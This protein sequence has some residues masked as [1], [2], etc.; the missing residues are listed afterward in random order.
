[1][2]C[3]K[4]AHGS[5]ECSLCGERFCDAQCWERSK[6][7]PICAS[8]PIGMAEELKEERLQRGQ[9]D[10]DFLLAVT[11]IKSSACFVGD[12]V[13]Y[14]LLGEEHTIKKHIIPN[15][16]DLE[17]LDGKLL[18]KGNDTRVMSAPRFLYALAAASKRNKQHMDLFLELDYIPQSLMHPER[19]WRLPRLSAYDMDIIAAVFSHMGCGSLVREEK[20]RCDV[21]PY[22]RFH[23]AD[24]RTKP[25]NDELLPELPLTMVLEITYNTLSDA[26]LN[27]TSEKKL[28]Q[29]LEYAEAISQFVRELGEDWLQRDFYIAL[30]SDHYLQDRWAFMED[31][32]NQLMKNTTHLAA[33]SGLV[34]LF[35]RV[36]YRSAH[37]EKRTYD[38][39]RVHE[40][41]KQFL[42]L[43]KEDPNMAE[44]VRLFLKNRYPWGNLSWLSEFGKQARDEDF[45]EDHVISFPNAGAVF[46]DI[47]LLCRMMRNFGTTPSFIKISYTGA[48]HAHFIYRF[49]EYI[50]P[51]GQVFTNMRDPPT[52]LDEE[53]G[54]VLLEPYLRSFAK[55]FINV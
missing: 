45:P 3:V 29:Y 50:L 25:W 14:W 39:T 47:P 40:V 16:L 53:E 32:Y 49:F 44:N 19:I 46:M 4:C 38:R 51:G 55:R 27:A 2:S 23:V 15:K 26:I 18:F 34:N 31:A 43:Q 48:G 28:K 35:K 11:G 21:H 52:Y 13:Q 10:D 22:C 42:K 7:G 41:R 12:N 36:Q 20:D 6:H 8:M 5:H 33:I 1:M 17:L 30:D 9:G 37:G 24:Y 54:V